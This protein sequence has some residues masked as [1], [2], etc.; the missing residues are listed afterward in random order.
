MELVGQEAIEA[1]GDVNELD[2]TQLE[3]MT[4]GIS[5]FTLEEEQW[6]QEA[7]EYVMNK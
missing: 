3:E 6:L 5:P 7:I 1:L 4:A 2:I